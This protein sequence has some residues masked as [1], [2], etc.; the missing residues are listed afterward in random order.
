MKAA[1][2]RAIATK[3]GAADTRRPAPPSPPSPPADTPPRRRGV[4]DVLYYGLLGSC[5]LMVLG[6]I[7]LVLESPEARDAR[8]AEQARQEQAR[9]VE[10]QQAE[11][12]AAKQAKED[13]KLARLDACSSVEGQAF[14][15]SQDAVRA[16]LKAPSTASFPWTPIQA[17]HTGDCKFQV[18]A[19]VD[20]QNGFGAMIRSNYMATLTYVPETKGWRVTAVRLEN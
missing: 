15:V 18:L 5:G 14:A 3:G 1:E 13:A 9:A 7:G 12:D 20:A 11:V 4:G 19:Y 16:K 2:L 8:L 17:Q 6:A 10:R